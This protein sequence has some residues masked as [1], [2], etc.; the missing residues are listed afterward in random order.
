[1]FKSPFAIIAC[2]G[3]SV[4]ALGLSL[5]SLYMVAHVTHES[6]QAVSRVDQLASEVARVKPWA[7]S[8]SELASAVSLVGAVPAALIDPA[9]SN[10]ATSEPIEPDLIRRYG[11]VSAQF[12]LVEYSDFEC[13]FCKEF[14]QVPKALV[15]GSRGNISV[16]FKHVPVHGDASRKQAFAA[17]CAADQGGNDA[18]FRMADAI[19]D[20]TRGNG[21]GTKFPLAAIA[22]EIGLNGRELSR[23]IDKGIY[24]EKVKAD[25]KEAMALS[26]KV[27]PTTVVRHNPTGKQVVIVGAVPPADLLKAMSELVAGAK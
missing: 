1:M 12:T 17:E 20:Q 10:E 18:F 21:S 4:A 2:L 27:T 26:V 25:F 24:F 14:F 6:A 7:Y 22:D 9:L 3:A 13:G 11:D 16:V 19:F 8:Q 15:D 23:C 5:L